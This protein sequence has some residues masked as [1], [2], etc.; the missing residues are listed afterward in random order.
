MA[1]QRRFV[2]SLAM[3]KV[4]I[5]LIALAAVAAGATVA[6]DPA[7]QPDAPQTAAGCG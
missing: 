3:T 5:G 4:L 7:W 1:P 2:S 6:V